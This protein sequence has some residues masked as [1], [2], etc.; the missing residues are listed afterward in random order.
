MTAPRTAA[1][2]RALRPATVALHLPVLA[3][4]TWQEYLDA[5]DGDAER[6]GKAARADVADRER[7]NSAARRFVDAYKPLIQHLKLPESPEDA[8]AV[9]TQALTTVKGLQTAAGSSSEA[10][11]ALEAAHA[12]LKKL[13]ID[14]EKITEGVAAAEAK[15]ARATKADELEREVTFGKAAAALKFD[16]AKLTRILRHEQGVPELR[17]VKVSV[18]KDGVTTEEDREVWGIPTRDAQGQETFTALTEHPDVKGFESSLKVTGDASAA[19]DVNAGM[20]VITT[21]GPST[22]PPA[23]ATFKFDGGLSTG[24]I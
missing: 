3:A 24:N 13:G 10:S 19:P 12:A 21:G 17:K 1:L 23:G 6:A 11:K 5:H 14:P 4:R 15:F 8:D 22:P 16:A 7:Q 18:L 20:P 2:T 9:S